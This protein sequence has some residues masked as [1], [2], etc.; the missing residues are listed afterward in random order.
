MIKDDI[1]NT[2]AEVDTLSLTV[3]QRL[4]VEI[5]RWYQLQQLK[6]HHRAWH[7]LSLHPLNTWIKILWEQLAE[8]K[9][10]L[11]PWQS[12]NLWLQIISEDSSRTILN[13]NKTA[14]LTSQAWQLIHHWSLPI[15]TFTRD[16]NEDITAFLDWMY[17]FQLKLNQLNAITEAELLGCLPPLLA[18]TNIK[19]PRQILLFGFDQVPPALETLL[20]ALSKTCEINWVDPV[21]KNNCPQLIAFDTPEEELIHI[22][23]WAI[24]QVNTGAKRVGI[25]FPDLNNVASQLKSQFRLLT[26]DAPALF[27]FSAGQSLY[28]QPIVQA[29]L[30]CLQLCSG[31][32]EVENLYHYLTSPYLNQSEEEIQSAALIDRKIREQ[33]AQTIDI[34][35]LFQTLA[36]IKL[37]QPTTLN[38]RLHDFYQHFKDSPKQQAPS[39]W[40]ETALSL[41]RIMGW[42]GGKTISSLEYQVMQRFIGALEEYCQLD[43]IYKKQSFSQ[44]LSLLKQLTQSIVFQAEGSDTPIQVLGTLESSG[45]TFDAIWFAGADIQTWPSS[46]N[47][48]PFIPL[49][50]QR[51]LELPHSSTE[52]ELQYCELITDRILS[53]AATSLCSYSKTKGEKRLDCSALLHKVKLQEIEPNDL[54]LDIDNPSESTHIETQIEQIDDHEGPAI[55]SDELIKGGSAILKSQ[56]NCAFQSFA[57]F[58]L[59]AQPLANPIY[60]INPMQRGNLVH[61]CLESIWNH[62][63]NHHSLCQLS[64]KQINQLIQNAVN[65]NLSAFAYH[66]QYFDNHYFTDVEQIRLTDILN[67]WLNLEKQRPPFEVIANEFN[68]TIEVGAL[69]MKLKIDRIDQLHS[70][71]RIII[72]YKTGN[73]QVSSWFGDRLLDP[74]LPLYCAFSPNDNPFKGISFAEIRSQK[75]QFKGV[76]S[77]S[78]DH[79]PTGIK[80]INQSRY[81]T[82]PSWD[83][84]LLHWQKQIGALSEKFSLGDA[85]VD[86]HS[87]LS[88]RYCDFKSFC[89]KQPC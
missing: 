47:P 4:S 64:E 2:A 1:I 52:K 18:K 65:E 48:N 20:N 80:P 35:F 19:L 22:A 74:Q 37:T 68:Q 70:G 14:Q 87:P 86:P 28:Q 11:S 33:Y 73:S 17:K 56:S 12:H 21:K 32:I 75:M 72:D 51:Q 5:K 45:L 16:V 50:I 26:D 83:L 23:R 77:E 82:Q 81:H 55:T 34:A 40:A 15:E 25:I 54:M 84:T 43:K 76:A 30:S 31:K 58:R 7:P 27:N 41:L 8:D 66:T 44:A 24:K 29:A 38:Q 53:S 57:M 67:R 78:I 69:K 79:L 89:R 49:L 6:Q 3:N 39:Q 62:I 36:K 63:E 88:C 13:P 60:G 46:A 10:L 9:T 42:P 85:T 61:Q 59:G 71:E